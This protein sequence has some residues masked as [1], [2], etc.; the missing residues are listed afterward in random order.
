MLTDTKILNFYPCKGSLILPLNIQSIKKTLISSGCNISDLFANYPERIFQTEAIT[1]LLK[2]PPK[3][4]ISVG[5]K[6]QGHQQ[7]HSNQLSMLHKLLI[8]FTS[9]N[10]FIK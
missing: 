7:N 8:G 10:N 2:K 3:Q 9:G 4:I 5:I 6:Q 1:S